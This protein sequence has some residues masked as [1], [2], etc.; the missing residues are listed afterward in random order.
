MYDRETMRTTRAE[1]Y[2]GGTNLRDKIDAR[3]ARNILGV[4]TLA[5][6][7]QFGYSSCGSC[8]RKQSPSRCRATVLRQP[9]DIEVPSSTP[10]PSQ[11]RRPPT[12]AAV[13]FLHFGRL[14]REV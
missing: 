10:I 7:I 2:D 4:E 11:S 8:L 1:K 14:G 9:I 6:R 13:G 12:L 5:P 3:E